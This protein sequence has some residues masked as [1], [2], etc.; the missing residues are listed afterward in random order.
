[1]NAR[2]PVAER[3]PGGLDRNRDLKLIHIAR[4]QLNMAEDAYRAIVLGISNQRTSSS[5]DLS[6]PERARLLQHLKA[7]G[8]TPK[9]ARP[10]VKLADDIHSRKV[11]SLWLQLA[12]ANKVTDRRE[13]ALVAYVKNKVGVDRLEWMSTAQFNV[14]VESLKQWLAR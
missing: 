14:V 12:D 10:S 5:A 2:V 8:F 6:G 1:M 11:R 13:S 7:C 4:K 9:P 3:H